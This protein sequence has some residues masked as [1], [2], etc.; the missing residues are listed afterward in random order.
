MYSS[1]VPFLSIQAFSNGTALSKVSVE[2]V[3]SGWSLPVYEL[4]LANASTSMPFALYWS[5]GGFPVH[6]GG[7][8]M[9]G[10]V[11]G[12]EASLQVSGFFTFVRVEV[13][14]QTDISRMYLLLVPRNTGNDSAW[15][16]SLHEP[17]LRYELMASQNLTTNSFNASN[18]LPV[19][20]LS[21]AFPIVTLSGFVSFTFHDIGCLEDSGG[22][23]CSPSIV[24][25]ASPPLALPASAAAVARNLE[26]LRDIRSVRVSTYD[27][28]GQ[29]MNSSAQYILQGVRYSVT[30]TEVTRN[31]TGTA[32]TS[33]NE[34]TWSPPTDLI[35]YNGTTSQVFN[36]PPLSVLFDPSGQG[37]RRLQSGF[38][39]L[40]SGWRSTVSE[41]VQGNANQDAVSVAVDISLNGQ[42]F[43]QSS[44]E[45]SFLHG[46][47]RNE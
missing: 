16:K 14:N 20:L 9:Q 25:E 36:V 43:T 12:Y 17:T 10:D 5:E 28:S 38:V 31:S 18:S 21:P 6:L 35:R 24:E 40:S 26:S 42:D 19:P 8:T 27:L 29:V 13:W 47:L 22:V 32:T 23:H 44:K 45:Y 7:F 30:F 46:C 2:T 1:S 34:V 15:E 37:Q 11:K 41:V 39:S 4:L 33:T 3:T